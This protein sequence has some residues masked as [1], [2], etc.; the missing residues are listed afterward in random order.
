M[1]VFLGENKYHL[2]RYDVYN[3]EIFPEFRSYIKHT[4]SIYK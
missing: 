3:R 2:D 4:Y 1:G